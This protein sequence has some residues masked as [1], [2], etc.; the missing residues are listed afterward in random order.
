MKFGM[1]MRLGPLYPSVRYNTVWSRLCKCKRASQAARNLLKMC[2]NVV[3]FM[4]HVK[5]CTSVHYRHGSVNIAENRLV[6]L[7]CR[8]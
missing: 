4:T 1:V 5:T 6:T 7:G 2:C 8:E 3:I